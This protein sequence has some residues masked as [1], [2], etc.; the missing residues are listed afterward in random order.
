MTI[1][2]ARTG[3]TR[4]PGSKKYRNARKKPHTASARPTRCTAARAAPTATGRPPSWGPN[5]ASFDR[6]TK[7]AP[8]ML[9]IPWTATLMA[10]G[11]WCA[12]A[13]FAD[14]TGVTWYPCRTLISRTASSA[15]ANDKTLAATR[16]SSYHWEAS[17][18]RC[19]RMASRTRAAHTTASGTAAVS[20]ATR[21]AITT[22]VSTAP[23]ADRDVPAPR[24]AVQHQEHQQQRERGAQM[25]RLGEH[26]VRVVAEL[27]RDH[28]PGRHREADQP[29][30]PRRTAPGQQPGRQHQQRIGGGARDVHVIRAQAAEQLDQRVFGN[31]GRVVRHVPEGPAAQ[32]PVAVQHVPA[33]QRLVSPVRGSG[34]RP[35]QPQV[36]EEQDDG[37]QDRAGQPH[38]AGKAAPRCFPCRL[39]SGKA[40]SRVLRGTLARRTGETSDHAQTLAEAPAPSLFL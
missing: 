13:S 12:D 30:P 9:T 23:T 5:G 14:A 33:L 18:L 35:G 21:S 29:F 22:Q 2:V 6:C 16:D 36:D 32:Q 19:L 39:L 40:S 3:E 25:I 4:L 11:R 26:Q 17:G 37:H 31:L 34:I 28:D 38:P 24:R 1:P 10:C 27:R 7:S 20:R 8:Y 15:T